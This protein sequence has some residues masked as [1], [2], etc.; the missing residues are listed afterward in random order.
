MPLICRNN[1]QLEWSEFFSTPL[2]KK[3]LQV[4]V[5]NYNKILSVNFITVLHSSVASKSG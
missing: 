5:L 2:N 4:N 3:M 1:F